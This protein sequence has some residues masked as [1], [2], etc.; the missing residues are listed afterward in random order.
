MS[1]G[2]LDMRERGALLDS[3]WDTHIVGAR[4]IRCGGPLLTIGNNGVGKR[5]V[6]Q[7]LSALDPCQQAVVSKYAIA[8]EATNS[9]ANMTIDGLVVH[10]QDAKVTH[11]IHRNDATI[12]V[13]MMNIHGYGYTGLPFYS[14][15]SNALVVY[16][17][18]D[19]PDYATSPGIKLYEDFIG[20]ALTRW[21]TM[22]GTDPTC[23]TPAITE[24]VGQPGGFV[25]LT[26]GSAGGLM[27]AN[28]VQ[29]LGS[30]SWRVNS[31]NLSI[32]FSLRNASGSDINVFLG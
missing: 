18:I 15:Q 1:G 32:S 24:S 9:V 11:L 21:Q 25:R 13:T 4:A 19:G 23:V 2:G 5:G 28:G 12:P 7:N 29:I 8:I 27:S 14:E 16:K 3:G 31:G 22:V 26:T 6:Y 20:S 17:G 30:R 10:S